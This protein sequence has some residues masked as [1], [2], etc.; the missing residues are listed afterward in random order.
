MEE[1]KATIQ[2][3]LHVPIGAVAEYRP[4][5]LYQ[6]LIEVLA[7]LERAKRTKQWL[8]SAIALKYEEQVRA[9]RLRQEKDTWTIHL[10]DNG[11][12]LTSEVAK[13]VEWNQTKL[14]E[15]ATTIAVNGGVLSDYVETYYTI[16]KTKYNGWS[17]TVKNLFEPARTVI[18]GKASYKLTRL[19]SEVG[20]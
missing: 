17:E 16:P 2:G 14:A 12:K 7:E 10:E 4:S 3:I 1:I 9:K 5:D 13:K 6:L 8:E 19:D 11:F 20:L 18:L 15:I